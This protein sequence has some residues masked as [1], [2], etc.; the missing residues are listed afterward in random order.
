MHSI[1]QK[2]L[3]SNGFLKISSCIIGYLLWAS[4]S[5]SH[6]STIWVEVPL[7]FY[8]KHEKIT[9]EAPETIQVELK[10][11]RSVLYNLEKA[12]L[13]VHINAQELKE[14]PNCCVINQSSMLL[15]SFINVNTYKPGNIVINVK[16]LI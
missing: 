11:R 14:G 7:S 5:D 8:N 1:I 15:P 3:L 9:I 6:L 13:A 2:A 10:A 4:L 16:K 12:N